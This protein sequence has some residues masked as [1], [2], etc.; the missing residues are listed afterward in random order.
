MGLICEVSGSLIDW[1]MGV[2]VSSGEK[3]ESGNFLKVRSRSNLYHIRDVDVINE[4][5]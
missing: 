5:A 3:D 2:V 4:V 1:K